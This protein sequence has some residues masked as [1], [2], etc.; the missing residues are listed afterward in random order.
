MF[1]VGNFPEGGLRE[2]KFLKTESF[3]NSG[4]PEV[5]HYSETATCF[6][7]YRQV[8]LHFNMF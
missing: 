3:R 1:T 4:F 5:P 2:G 7:L 8:G 6:L